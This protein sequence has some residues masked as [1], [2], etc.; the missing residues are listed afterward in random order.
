M[1]ASTWNLLSWGLSGVN[2]ALGQESVYAPTPNWVGHAR[3][4]LG[5]DVAGL[6]ETGGYKAGSIGMTVAMAVRDLYKLGRSLAS[7]RRVGGN[8]SDDAANLT[9]MVS[10]RSSNRPPTLNEVGELGQSAKGMTVNPD[11]YVH[12][13]FV[14]AQI[15]TMRS[16][17]MFTEYGEWFVIAADEVIRARQL[18]VQ[19]NTAQAVERLK[20]IAKV[21]E[22]R[23]GYTLLPENVANMV[24]SYDR[25]LHRLAAANGL[26]AQELA[27]DLAPWVRG[28]VTGRP[29]PPHVLDLRVTIRQAEKLPRVQPND[30]LPPF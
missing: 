26:S 20:T 30:A 1:P 25:K 14:H 4:A 12:D 10:D 29:I 11:L 18:G 6:E 15:D 23:A 3:V 17:A 19:P 7:I 5:T 28:S 21:L 13:F 24:A 8:A 22:K 9:R 2:R 16:G 27:R